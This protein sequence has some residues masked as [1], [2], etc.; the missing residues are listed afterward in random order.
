[1][2]ETVTYRYDSNR[3]LDTAAFE[4]FAQKIGRTNRRKIDTAYENVLLAAVLAAEV[5]AAEGRK[6]IGEDLRRFQTA[7]MWADFDYKVNKKSNKAGS[8][9]I[10]WV[11]RTKQYYDWQERGTY[12]QRN[13]KVTGRFY[14]TGKTKAKGPGSGKGITPMY[15]IPYAKEKFHQEFENNLRSLRG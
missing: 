6:Y 15:A 13:Q 9:S 11:N 8:V 4:G 3:Y 1:M 5:A 12:S 14:H 7:N 2:V 10:G